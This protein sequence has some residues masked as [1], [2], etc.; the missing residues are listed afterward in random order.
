M[1]ARVVLVDD[2][3][4]VR[5]GLRALL[6]GIAG[7][8]VV[9]EAG[10]GEEALAL[11]RRDPPD[12]LVTDIS[13]KRLNGLQLTERI[14]REHPAVKIIILSM[15]SGSSYVQHALR[16]GAAAYLVKD[17][18]THE[19]ELA[20]RAVLRGENYLSP[21]VSKQVVAA[22]VQSSAA[23]VEALTARQ[24]EILTFIAEGHSTKEIAYRLQL[25]VKTIETHRAQIMERL[26]IRDIPG[27]VRF[28]IRSGLVSVDG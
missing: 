17:A 9:A 7:I 22:Y 15:H 12:V 6:D 8:E 24:R 19:L 18:V 14:A 26:A 2:H 21:S 3:T 28:A 16:A 10:D 27:L 25:S 1:N 23:P 20:V 11:I 13:M 4:L 5:A